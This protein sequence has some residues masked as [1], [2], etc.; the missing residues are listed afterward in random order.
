MITPPEP[1]R[2]AVC[3]APLDDATDALAWCEEHG[4]PVAV[5]LHWRDCFQRLTGLEWTTTHYGLRGAT[6][7][8]ENQ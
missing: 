2:C 5:H 4:Q 3:G 8:T 6:E 7:R 1:P